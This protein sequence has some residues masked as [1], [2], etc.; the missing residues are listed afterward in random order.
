MRRIPIFALLAIIISSPAFSEDADSIA[1]LPAKEGKPAQ[2]I[3][4]PTEKPQAVVESL[5][6]GPPEQCPKEAFWTSA[7]SPGALVSCDDGRVYVI[8]PYEITD[9]S[10][11][12]LRLVPSV[13]LN[14]G[15]PGD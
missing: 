2:T 9:N 5:L 15:T 6:G 10:K 3:R 1:Y 13:E 7:A 8:R 11:Y 12:M 4:L 14:P